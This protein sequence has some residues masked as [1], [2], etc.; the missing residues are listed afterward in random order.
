MAH[1]PESNRTPRFWRDRQGVIM[2]EPVRRWFL[3]RI[4]PL[5][6]LFLVLPVYL[7]YQLGVLFT[8]RRGPS[9]AYQ[10]VGNGVDFLTG[11][12]LSLSG[13]SLAVYA[14]VTSAVGAALGGL[15]LWAR[16]RSKLSPRL[17]IP[18]VIESGVYALLMAAGVG[19]LVSSLGLGVLDGLSLPAQWVSSAGAGLH[20][21]LV[22]RL[23]LFH[24]LAYLA[25]PR[26]GRWAGWSLALVV[27][28]T[29]F[30]A[31][32]YLGPLG[33]RLTVESFVFR[34]FLGIVLSG[35]YRFRGFAIAVWTHFLYD[36]LY[37][38]LRAS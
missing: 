6:N 29:L 5:T 13:G 37:F 31:M 38:T 24:G 10:W 11:T 19:A 18:V 25:V 2:P 4:D 17:F 3:P 16:R 22:F 1:E 32:H 7:F 35:V 20:E 15:T 8:L 30:S 23:G 28:A 34:L 21:E 26:L 12:L 36:V 33:D 9:G 27:S 14:G